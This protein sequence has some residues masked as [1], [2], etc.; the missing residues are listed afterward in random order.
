MP[1]K[2][3]KQ[4]KHVVKGNGG[5]TRVGGARDP[6]SVPFIPFLVSLTLPLTGSL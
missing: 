3:V 2:S 6:L 4:G 1:S 5:G